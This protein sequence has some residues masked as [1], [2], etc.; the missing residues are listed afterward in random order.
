MAS[1]PRRQL[2]N[3]LKSVTV[4]GRVADVGVEKVKNKSIIGNFQ[5]TEYVTFEKNEHLKIKNF[6]DQV[7]DIE[8]DHLDMASNWFQ[9]FD[10]VLATEVFEYVLN[11]RSVA[12]NLYNMLKPG[13]KLI[14]SWVFIYPQH[15]SGD[16]T[17]LTDYGAD[18]VFRQ[19]G[20]TEISFKERTAAD[21]ELLKAFYASEDFHC[22]ELRTPDY[23]YPVGFIMEARR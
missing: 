7:L 3:Y 15:G 19:A 12:S 17:R 22:P 2:V 18:Y 1:N 8:N 11:Y 20:F 21:P 5:A 9:H 13:G 4:T 14:A 6:A 16:F 23:N 10:Y